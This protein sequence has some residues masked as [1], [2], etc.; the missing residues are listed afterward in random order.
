MIKPHRPLAIGVVADHYQELDRL[1]REI[2]GEHVHHGL[3]R[4][5]RETPLEAVE[6][7]VDFVAAEA[8]IQPGDRVCDIG[9]GYGAGARYMVR[10]FAAKVTALTIVPAQ[11]AYAESVAPGTDN[12]R[13][14]LRDWL[15]ND[16]PDAAFDAAYAIESTE[17]ME[18]KARAF[19]EAYR[20]MKPGGRLAICAWIAKEEAR[21]WERRH[22]LEPICREGRLPGMGTETDYRQLLTAAG[23]AVERV[24]DITNEVRDTWTI[25]LRRAGSRFF[26]DRAARSFLFSEASRNRV[27]L[28]TMAR[29]WAAYRTGA[30]R[31]LV[32]RAHKPLV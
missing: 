27:F 12:P 9:S 24:A 7:L 1:Y 3:W 26:S 17:H 4:T 21:A 2:W 30:M 10:M 15:H 6:Q 29:I 19:A 13:Y 8:G 22:L 28:L 14:L 5:G 25:C 31:Y 16:L 11:Q 20:V 18:D 23:F 32:F